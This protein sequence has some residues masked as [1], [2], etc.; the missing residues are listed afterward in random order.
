MKRKNP[1]LRLLLAPFSFLYGFITGFRNQLFEW[2]ILPAERYPVPVI[3]VGNIT[4][5]GTGKTPFTEYLIALIKKRYRIAALSRG[6]MR[7]TKGFLWV[8]QDTDASD[9]GDE[10][11]QIK[12]KFPDITVAVDSNR[13]R[14]IHRLLALPKAEQPE[15]ILLDDAFQHRF[16]TPSLSIMLTDFNDMYYD[17][18]LLPAGNLR[19]SMVGVYR[20]DIIVVTKCNEIM[21][22]IDL[23][24]IEKN[25]NLMASQHLYFSKIKYLPLEALFPLHVTQSFSLDASKPQDVELLL[26]AGIAKPQQFVNQVKAYKTPVK[27]FLFRD[28]HRFTA[29][30]IQNIHA[31]FQK[32]SPK[33]RRIITTEKDAMRL[34]TLAFLPDEWKSCLFFLP[35]SVDF[36][37]D[38]SETFDLRILTHIMSTINIYRKNVKN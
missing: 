32:L 35:V 20:A 15:V 29:S 37:F 8:N 36:L 23:R 16:V 3:C 4:V 33:K 7:N 1:F 34:K 21:K 28:H 5:G 30:D 18:A 12:R 24:I 38:Q 14:G 25:M 10:A 11:C 19:E 31:E 17:D 26:I 6:Y 22:P 13:R 27:T 9:A 2:K